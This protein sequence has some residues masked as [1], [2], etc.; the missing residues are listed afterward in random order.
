MDKNG[1]ISISS[2]HHAPGSVVNFTPSRIINT[3]DF[4]TL[5]CSGGSLPALDKDHASVTCV[6]AAQELQGMLKLTIVGIIQGTL[7]G[8]RGTRWRNKYVHVMQQAGTNKCT[9]IY[10]NL[11]ILRFKIL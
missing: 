1:H 5:R 8:D 2:Y 11:S 7:L 4:A 10:T 9:N 6:S 3:M